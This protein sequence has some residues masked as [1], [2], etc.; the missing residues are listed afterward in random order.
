M[1]CCSSSPS[2]LAGCFFMGIVRSSAI[3]FSLLRFY[4]A[5][6]RSGTLRGASLEAHHF[7]QLEPISILTAFPCTCVLG[8]GIAEN[9]PG[10]GFYF[11]YRSRWPLPPSTGR[12]RRR[13]TPTGR[14]PA[15]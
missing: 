13:K 9:G 10:G 3:S 6:G 1:V 8:P 7:M 11:L 14:V 4:P 2:P 15:C 5:L 12:Y